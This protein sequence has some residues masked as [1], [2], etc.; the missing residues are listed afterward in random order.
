MVKNTKHYPKKWFSHKH[1]SQHKKERNSQK[2]K[3]WSKKE[4]QIKQTE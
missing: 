1:N 2:R 4:Q 3:N